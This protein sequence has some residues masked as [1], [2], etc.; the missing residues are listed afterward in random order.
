M[1]SSFALKVG[2]NFAPDIDTVALT[3]FFF[4]SVCLFIE[5]EKENLTSMSDFGMFCSDY[6]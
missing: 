3:I 2:G 4:P 6:T 5:A 1:G